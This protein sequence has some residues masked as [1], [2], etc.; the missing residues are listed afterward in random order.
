MT[1]IELNLED[2]RQWAGE[3]Y[4][5]NKQDAKELPVKSQAVKQLLKQGAEIGLKIGGISSAALLDS[6]ERKIHY[7]DIAAG[8]IKDNDG[9]DKEA[10]YDQIVNFLWVNLNPLTS[11]TL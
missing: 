9:T 4:D 5:Y 1:S 2:Y 7:A 10:A 8:Y 6:F 3:H 11:D